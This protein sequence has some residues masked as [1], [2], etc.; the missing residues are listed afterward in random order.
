[1]QAIARKA[2]FSRQHV[3]AI[4]KAGPRLSDAIVAR[5]AAAAAAVEAAEANTK[6]VMERVR[7]RCRQTG[8]RAFAR[9]AG[10]DDGLLA[11]LL[12]GSRRPSV[13]ALAAL[14]RALWTH[15]T[16]PDELEAHVAD[17]AKPQSDQTATPSGNRK[18]DHDSDTHSVAYP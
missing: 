11:H 12:A 15:P 5:L 4:L 17:I 2:R 13:T 10:I 14:R 9:L 3:A 1:M 6:H 8:L 18:P 16:Q 7:K